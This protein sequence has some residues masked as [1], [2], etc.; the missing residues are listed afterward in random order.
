[1][2]RISKVS[3]KTRET[4]ILVELSIDGEGKASIDS[5]IGFLNHMLEALA[6]HG[7]FDLKIEAQGDIYVDQH[8]LVEDLA[9]VIGRAFQE[10][11]GDK[12]GIQRGGFFIYPMDDALALVAIDLSGR[13][14]LQFNATFKRQF[15]GD[16]DTDLTKHFFEAL[17]VSMGANFVVKL[18]AGENDHH[19]LEAIFKALAKSLKIAC[20]VDPRASNSI[21]STKEVLD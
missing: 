13:P 12:K 7:L 17:S 2:A 18:M 10:A 8:H 21:P 5:P 4:Q 16:F 6:K 20:M 3:R 19:K 14:Y 11:L 15:C 9:I 1:M